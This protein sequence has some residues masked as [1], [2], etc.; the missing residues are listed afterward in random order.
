MAASICYS[1]SL[2]G[3]GGW[4]R[5]KKGKDREEVE[6]RRRGSAKKDTTSPGIPALKRIEEVG[7]FCMRL[8]DDAPMFPRYCLCK[9]SI[10]VKSYIRS[11]KKKKNGEEEEGKEKGDTF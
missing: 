2:R 1:H 4:G 10:L 8:A 5:R 7:H 11:K 3:H 6:R 9:L